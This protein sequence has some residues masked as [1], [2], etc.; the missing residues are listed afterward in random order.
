MGGC[1]WRVLR[2]GA[3]FKHGDHLLGDFVVRCLSILRKKFE[4]PASLETP[5]TQ[6]SSQESLKMD[7][8]GDRPVQL[9]S[10]VGIRLI[11]Q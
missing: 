10:R 11:L 5:R 8:L 2:G 1:H 6:R 4:P 7:F 9:K 3:F